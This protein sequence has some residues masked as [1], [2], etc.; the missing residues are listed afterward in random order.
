MDVLLKLYDWR[1]KEQGVIVV[2][3][4][5]TRIQSKTVMVILGM[6]FKVKVRGRVMS[7]GGSKIQIMT[8]TLI[9][10]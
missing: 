8:V 5:R 3:R 10:N 2:G 4:W 1:N 6:G 9:I 7:G